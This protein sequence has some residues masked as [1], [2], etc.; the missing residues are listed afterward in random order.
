MPAPIEAQKVSDSSDDKND[1]TLDHELALLSL[2]L[3][4][5]EEPHPDLSSMARALSNYDG[6]QPILEILSAS[7]QSL[8]ANPIF[9]KNPVPTKDQMARGSDYS[10]GQ[11]SSREQSSDTMVGGKTHAR[12]LANFSTNQYSSTTTNELLLS[13]RTHYTIPEEIYLLAPGQAQ[14]KWMEGSDR[15]LDDIQVG[16]LARPYSPNDQIPLPTKECSKQS[17]VVLSSSL[18]IRDAPRRG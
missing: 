15:H 10:R 18:S 9:P 16:R 14:S 6:L 2:L 7:L 12:P 5:F 3:I 1:A 17:R 13:V 8:P 4:R 11:A